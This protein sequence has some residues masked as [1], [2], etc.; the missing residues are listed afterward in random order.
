VQS[1]EALL[2]TFNIFN[3]GFGGSCET[4]AASGVSLTSCCQAFQ[5]LYMIGV[6]TSLSDAPFIIFDGCDILIVIESLLNYYQHVEE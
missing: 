2:L 4:Q 5:S 3:P 1:R 6:S